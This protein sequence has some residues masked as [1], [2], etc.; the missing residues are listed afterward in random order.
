V[1]KAFGRR[2]WICIWRP[3]FQ[4]KWKNKHYSICSTKSSDFLNGHSNDRAD[5]FCEVQSS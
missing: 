2:L 1:S 5:H 3:S 4:C